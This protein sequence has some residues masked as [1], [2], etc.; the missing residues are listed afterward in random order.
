[1]NKL[2]ERSVVEV[3]VLSIVTFGIYQL[4]WMYI[5][6]K[7]LGES[8]QDVV[9]VKWFIIPVVILVGMI[10]IAATLLI[11]GAVLGKESD[12]GTAIAATGAVFM[13]LT[14]TLFLPA[15]FAIYGYWIYW[16]YKF[17][18][19]IDKLTKEKV[20]FLVT[21]LLGLLVGGIIWTAITQHLLNEN[22]PK[23]ANS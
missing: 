7:E 10:I 21:F 6:N 11:I 13:F 18:Q 2:H 17:S 23:K 3:V 5:T 14:Y 22:L 9:P 12:V 1:M 16:L 4:Y 15:F 20:Q 8:K 19:A